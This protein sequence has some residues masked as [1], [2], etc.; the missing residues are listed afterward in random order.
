MLP[1]I[2]EFDIDTETA[3]LV[4]KFWTLPVCQCRKN[5][6]TFNVWMLLHDS[7]CVEIDEFFLSKSLSVVILFKFRE[8]AAYSR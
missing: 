4:F 2:K 3:V 5:G 6:V 1:D 7:K 8:S